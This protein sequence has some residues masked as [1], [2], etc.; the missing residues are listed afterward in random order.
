MT[1]QAIEAREQSALLRYSN[2]AATF[3]WVTVAL[4]LFQL[5]EHYYLKEEW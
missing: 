2:V 3:H 5:A 4:V 1:D